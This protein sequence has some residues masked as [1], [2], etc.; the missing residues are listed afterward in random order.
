MYSKAGNRVIANLWPGS[1]PEPITAR[2]RSFTT[3][4]QLHRNRGGLQF[5]QLGRA[6]QVAD[7]GWS[8]GPVMADLDNDGYL[9]LFATC[10]FISRS[11]DDPDG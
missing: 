6:M 4:S 9:D 8:Y 7:V 11:R 5:E 3:G 2:L 1:Y 10:G